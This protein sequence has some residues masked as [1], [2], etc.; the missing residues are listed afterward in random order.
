MTK[1][2]G[3]VRWA[4]VGATAHITIT[5]PAARNAMSWEMYDQLG[6]VLDAIDATDGVR[7]AVLRGAG[8]QWIAGTD[9][10]EF[11]DV[12]TGDDGVAYERRLDAVLQRLAR[13]RVPTLAV[14][15]G[16]AMGGGMAIAA[17]CD[18]RMMTPDARFGVPIA[19]TLGNCL[20]I[21][22][23]AHLVMHLG[24]SRVMQ[25]VYTAEPMDAA[26]ALSRGFVLEVASPDTL[27]ARVAY[28]CEQL[29]SMAPLTLRVTRDAVRRIV[30]AVAAQASLEPREAREQGEGGRGGKG[31]DDLLRLVYGSRDFREGVEAFLA[32]RAP[33]WEGR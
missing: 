16:Q 11:V 27:D 10:A 26:E 9:I 21:T 14:V 18:L 2:P 17:A 23:Y 25:L 19:R 20:S 7:V 8:G 30:A 22:T 32:R 13:V 33:R 29:G 6:A 15:E 4:Q 1:E 12:T 24:A 31:G 28:R 3:E 5:R